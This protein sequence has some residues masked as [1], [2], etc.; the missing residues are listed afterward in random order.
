MNGTYVLGIINTLALAGIL[1]AL[2][3]RDYKEKRNAAR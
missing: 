1:W 3:R 2:C